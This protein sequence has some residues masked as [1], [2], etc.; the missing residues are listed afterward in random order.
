MGE[1]EG[2]VVPLLDLQ[3]EYA[4]LRQRIL[5]AVDE[6]LSSGQLYLGPQ[7]RALE[8]EFAQYCGAAHGVACSSGTDALI[9]GLQALGIG[10]GD[11]VIT[12]SHTFI[13]TVAAIMLAGATPVFVDID[14]QTYTMNVPQLAASLTPRT[15]AVLPVHLYGHPVDMEPL[16]AFA[17][18]HGLAVVEDCAQAH[19]AE[20]RG[21]RAGSLGDAGCF[22]FVFTKNLRAYGDA[23][24]LLTSDAAV[25][26]RA[27]RLLDHGRSARYEHAVIGWNMRM[28][29]LHAAVLR[30]K[31]PLLDGWTA[32][33]REHARAY[34]AALRSAGGVSTPFAAPD[35]MHV[36]HQYVVGVD[37]RDAVRQRLAR[38]GVETGVHYPIP[39]HLQEAC[40]GLGYRPGDLP[41]TERAA[42][43]VLSLP[44]YPELTDEQRGYVIECVKGAVGDMVMQEQRA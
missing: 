6:V 19:G 44:V 37:E 20:Y 38:R 13:A 9:L 11:E 15:R 33:R 7:T 21:R 40:R 43:R 2:R 31:L 23:G 10:P 16:L 29:E 30:L 34:D 41:A 39:C 18:R 17:K 27:R 3:A 5:H 26:E 8:A 35:V 22:S 25:A 14:A 1:N 4:P 28:D 36:Y 42:A 24:M 12:V 32:S